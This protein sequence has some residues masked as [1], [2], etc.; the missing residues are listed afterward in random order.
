MCIRDSDVPTNFV[1]YFFTVFY[2]LVSSK[3]LISSAS[4]K[5]ISHIVEAL[6]KNLL[7]EEIAKLGDRNEGEMIRKQM[8]LST[9]RIIEN[10]DQTNILCAFIK[11]LAKHK[12]D[13]EG[14]RLPELIVKCLL[15]VIKDIE[16]IFPELRV[17][18]ILLEVHEHLAGEHSDKTANGQ[19]CLRAV[20]TI[21]SELVKQAKE[22]IWKDY[23]VVEEH[24]KEDKDIR[25]WIEIVL[26]TVSLTSDEPQS[27]E[28]L[29][30]LRNNKER[31]SMTMKRPTQYKTKKSEYGLL[32]EQTVNRQPSRRVSTLSGKQ[33]VRTKSARPKDFGYN[34][35]DAKVATTLLNASNAMLTQRILKMT[36]LSPKSANKTLN[37]INAQKDKLSNI[38][39]GTALK[40]KD[41]KVLKK[42]S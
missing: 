23:K 19:L 21:V 38:S 26:S 24:E 37:W 34:E 31:L 40:R 20:K 2:K 36:N 32:G 29:H 25:R 35:R 27:S 5:A 30:D 33:I 1:L 22:D 8:N 13:T 42:V 18:E 14:T 15:R 9:F 7:K 41:T 16:A 6:L 11:L 3:N 39:F 12:E 17:S 28:T 4:T 10:C